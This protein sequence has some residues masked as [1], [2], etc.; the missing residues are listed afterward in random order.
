MLYFVIF[1]WLSS[2]YIYY[3]V[4]RNWRMLPKNPGGLAKFSMALDCCMGLMFL[5]FSLKITSTSIQGEHRVQTYRAI[6]A[7]GQQP[8]PALEKALELLPAADQKIWRERL[9]VEAIK[10]NQKQSVQYFLEHGISA[11]QLGPEG[12]PW[13]IQSLLNRASSEISCLIISYSKDPNIANP[14]GAVPALLYAV[15]QQDRAVITL[16][17]KRGADPKKTAGNGESA[18]QLAQSK[19]PDLLPLLKSPAR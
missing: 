14:R 9:L 1:V 16:L 17:M 15:Q 3:R 10:A 13:V 19:F 12:V 18:L 8:G 4:W 7:A 2:F 11:D 6:R 5:A